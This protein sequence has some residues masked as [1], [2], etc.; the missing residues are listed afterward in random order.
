MKWS[1]GIL[2]AWMLPLSLQPSACPAGDGPV[3]IPPGT[4]P[5]YW[6]RSSLYNRDFYTLDAAE[7]D[8]LLTEGA[9]LWVYEQVAFR[10]FDQPV[11]DTLAPVHRFWSVPLNSHFYT[12]DDAEADKAIIDYPNVW[13]YE[14]VAFFAYPQGNHPV[15]TIP[16][17]RFWSDALGTHRYTTSDRERFKLSYENA[18]VWQY[19]GVAW[20][21]YPAD[22]LSVVEIVK[23][24]AIEWITQESATLV[25]ETDVPSGAEVRYGISSA[26][27]NGVSDPAWITLHKVVLSDLTPDTLYTYVVKSGTAS[28]TGTFRTAPREGQAFRFAVL[29]D[30]QWDKDTHRQIAADILES[31]PGLVLHCGDLTSCGR[32]LD[33]W[34]TEFF[35]PASELLA[36]IPLVAVPGNHEYF[37]LGPPWFFYWFDR[38]VN[39]GWFALEYGNAYFI[40]LH[41]GASFC[42]GSP[43]YEWLV[44]E[45]AS[46]ACRNAM[47]RVVFFH[48]PPFTSTNGHTDNLAAQDYLV[49]LFEQYGVDV[50]F[51]GH[52][53]VYE[54][55]FH[56]GVYYIVTGGAGGYLYTLVADKT[57]PIR[58]FGLSIHHYCIVDVDPAAGTLRISAIDMT[59]EIFDSIDLPREY[60]AAIACHAEASP[61]GD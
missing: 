7:R 26:D 13:T 2:T 34:E 42:P 25:W 51:S 17:Y 27:Q 33:L 15:G 29:S 10:A 41:T 39:D 30:T 52:S 37:G 22:S 3:Q 57:P 40:G 54:R 6:F 4:V 31:Q 11:G 9:P 8:L 35:R 49:P 53:H 20:Y 36:N 47:W 58:E 1:L 12:I 56:N 32:S 28:R 46:T 55:Y 24:P 61:T 38:P 43:Q 50:V 18:A 19:E 16:A 14:G 44:R 60:Q 21:A 23:G 45:L 48:E 59:G 5:V